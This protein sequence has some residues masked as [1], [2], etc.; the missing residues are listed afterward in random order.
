MVNMTTIITTCV[1]DV[2]DAGM[3]DVIDMKSV[4]VIEKGNA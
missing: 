3:K 4:I 2:I 1:I